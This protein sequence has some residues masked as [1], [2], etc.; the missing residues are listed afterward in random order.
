MKIT[1]SRILFIYIHEL[2][3]D[4]TSDKEICCPN[5]QFIQNTNLIRIRTAAR[6]QR[7]CKHTHYSFLKSP[8]V[9]EIDCRAVVSWQGATPSGTVLLCG[10]FITLSLN[11]CL[12][13]VTSPL[14]PC[15]PQ[16]ALPAP[17]STSLRFRNRIF[18]PR[19]SQT[20]RPIF[21][22]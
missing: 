18:K 15:H 19:K 8:L 5:K 9:D 4:G 16:S 22:K 3:I 12:S 20:E 2:L 6:V 1:P 11:L 7:A 21:R 10:F 13:S 14:S 17:P